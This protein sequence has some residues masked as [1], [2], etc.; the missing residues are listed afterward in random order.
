MTCR[1][2]IFQAGVPMAR[3]AMIYSRSRMENI[4]PRTSRD[5]PIQPK[6]ADEDRQTLPGPG[7]KMRD[8]MINKK[9]SGMLPNVMM[10]ALIT[11]SIQVVA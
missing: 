11:S 5:S 9:S 2:M 4:W 6:N 10:T 8:R 3:L 1:I 7:W